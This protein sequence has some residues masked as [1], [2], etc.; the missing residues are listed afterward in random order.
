M[1]G[2][3]DYL[4]GET[5]LAPAWM[6]HA[7][8]EGLYRLIRQPRRWRRILVAV[9]LFLWAVLRDGTRSDYGSVE[10]NLS[11]PLS[12]L[13]GGD[14]TEPALD[15]GEPSRQPVRGGVEHHRHRRRDGGAAHHRLP[16]AAVTTASPRCGSQ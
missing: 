11:Y 3:F 4:A 9:P 14:L 16:V 13:S 5:P 8:L 7:G 12:K 15:L 1:G 10:M 2:V 6:R